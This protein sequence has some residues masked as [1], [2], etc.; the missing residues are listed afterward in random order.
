M[1][2][3]KTAIKNAAPRAVLRLSYWPARWMNALKT[4]PQSSRDILVTLGDKRPNGDI[5]RH[6]Y[7]IFNF[8]AE[9]GYNIYVYQK[10][11]F[12]FYDWLKKYGRH[13]FSVKRLKF[14]TRVPDRTE[15]MIYMFDHKDLDETLLGRK[16]K[17]LVYLSVLKPT[18]WQVGKDRMALPF[19]MHPLIYCKGQDKQLNVFRGQA[20]KIRAFF[21]GNA[22]KYYYRDPAVKKYGQMTRREGIAALLR[23]RRK[24]VWRP[25]KKEFDHLMR[26][27]GYRVECVIS[28]FSKFKIRIE[29]WLETLSKS[30][31]FLCLS[32]AG[33]PMCHHLIESLA[34]GTVPIMSYP[35]WLE[36][37]LEHGK[38]AL[39]YRNADE[40]VQRL[41]EAM[42]MSPVRIGE[43]R[44]NAARYYDEHLSPRDFSTRFGSLKSP[45]ALMQHPWLV[46][47]DP[48]QNAAARLERL[49]A[50]I[51]EYS[52][53]LI[54]AA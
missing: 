18:S 51:V 2:G 11:N 31:F 34:V 7:S 21:A 23:S 40:L 36:P 49:N 39:I 52:R 3:I 43:M 54:H 42:S 14:I 24:I 41:D 1:F 6:L 5:P 26:A 10:L 46:G 17:K 53:S 16:W 33:Y 30:D 27:D 19:M 47:S 4:L 13:L 9:A 48:D 12:Q 37:P 44:Q 15:N 25:D 28:D 38:N 22:D 8:L 45:H 32:G 29:H 20:R 50:R 35:E